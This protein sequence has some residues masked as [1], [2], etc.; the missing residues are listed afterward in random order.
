MKFKNPFGKKKQ[1]VGPRTEI[2]KR[3]ELLGRVGQGSMSRVWRAND[4]LSNQMVALKVLDREKTKRFES[5]FIGL[6]K[7]PEGEIAVSLDHPNCVRTLEHGMTTEEEPFLVMEF[8]EGMGL[9]MLVELQ[10][11]RMRRYRLSLMIQIGDSLDYLHQAGWIHRDICPRNIL[12]STENKI[13]LIDFGLVVPNTPNFRKPGNRTGTANYMAPELIKR[14]TTDER[15][16]IFSYAV[17]CF[18]MYTKRHPW[19][20]AMTLD[21]VIQH[22]N[23]PPADIREFVPKIDDQIANTIMK[24]LQARP[25]DR[26][27]SMAEMTHEFREAEAR[28]VAA[29]RKK[30]AAKKQAGGKKARVKRPQKKRPADTSKIG[31]KKKPKPPTSE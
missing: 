23:K 14:Q 21:A 4:G 15:I 17:T 29:A 5:R 30:M 12:L 26:W 9:G 31:V 28:L 24:G 7:P 20:A 6:N 25:D 3:F 11:D 19:D 16:D 13:K 1:D 22:I 27:Q 8:V 2:R 18:E 10:D